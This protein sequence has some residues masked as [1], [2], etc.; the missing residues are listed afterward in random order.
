[1]TGDF[2]ALDRRD[3]VQGAALAMASLLYPTP[4]V[5][6][7]EAQAS[8]LGVTRLNTVQKILLNQ[9]LYKDVPAYL[10]F[11]EVADAVA[12]KVVQGE[13]AATRFDDAYQKFAQRAAE[14]RK[15]ALDRA[16]GRGV[17]LD[18][19]LIPSPAAPAISIA[20]VL[21]P[22][23]VPLGVA[24]SIARQIELTTGT[25]IPVATTV[26]DVLQGTPNVSLIP[27]L[28]GALT[29][30][31]LEQRLKLLAA[32][33]GV[34]GILAQASAFLAKGGQLTSEFENALAGVPKG[35]D[36]WTKGINGLAS[37]APQSSSD[38]AA[39]Q[40]AT[41]ALASAFEQLGTSIGMNP[42]TVSDVSK[43]VN[44]AGAALAGAMAGSVFGPVG[45]VVGGVV[46]L[47][48]GLLGSK[49][50][51][52]DQSALALVRIDTRITQ[53][54]QAMQVG[55]NAISAQMTAQLTSIAQSM[56]SGF[57]S[58][59]VQIRAFEIKTG[60]SLARIE[61]DLL[62]LAAT[63]LKNQVNNLD[64]VC[65]EHEIQYR[66]FVAGASSNR[67]HTEGE[68]RKAAWTLAQM[69]QTGGEGFSGPQFVGD[70]DFGSYL[71]N[72]SRS[73]ATQKINLHLSPFMTMSAFVAMVGPPEPPDSLVDEV[74]A[75]SEQLRDPGYRLG[76]EHLRDARY[77]VGK[78]HNAARVIRG[79][80]AECVARLA[81][82]ETAPEA[83]GLGARREVK[84]LMISDLASLPAATA[85]SDMWF[86]L[87]SAQ[88]STQQVSDV[89][90]LSGV[91]SD[92]SS[93]FKPHLSSHY[94][95]T[96]Q[97]SLPALLYVRR[98]ITSE[99]A[100]SCAVVF[101]NPYMAAIDVLRRVASI[102]MSQESGRNLPRASRIDIPNYATAEDMLRSYERSRM[103]LRAVSSV[104][105]GAKPDNLAQD[106]IFM[107]GP[108]PEGIQVVGDLLGQIFSRQVVDPGVAPRAPWS[109]YVQRA[110][111]YLHRTG[112]LTRPLVSSVRSLNKD[113]G[114]AE[115]ALA[116]HLQRIRSCC[117]I[118]GLIERRVAIRLDALKASA[119]GGPPPVFNSWFPGFKEY[120]IVA[121]YALGQ[122]EQNDYS[123]AKGVMQSIL[124]DP[125]FGSGN[126]SN[127]L[128]NNA[129]LADLPPAAKP[130][131]VHLGQFWG[132]GAEAC[133]PGTPT[134]PQL[135]AA[136]L[137]P[138]C[139]FAGENGAVLAAAEIYSQLKADQAL[140]EGS[141]DLVDVVQ[142]KFPNGIRQALRDELKAT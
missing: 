12:R 72:Y 46:G 109:E 5:G 130:Y 49:S 15:T 25:A 42:S 23:M 112:V 125:D 66:N 51:G 114:P 56:Q 103:P 119:S 22:L 71:A 131:P 122:T 47:V 99:L 59:S 19:V 77:P 86:L 16:I 45:T 110:I 3:F 48:S 135:L 21:S 62:S 61:A 29:G 38:A 28:P 20:S 100:D 85:P 74:K 83:K 32:E 97:N 44:V 78:Q 113:G 104:D 13:A 81:G 137:R 50:R 92:L 75:V 76:G 58:L 31:L 101:C 65:R 95:L 96:G 4:W 127:I 98:K 60:G 118:L 94:L 70:L 91:L 121:S 88:K 55:F 102:K 73:L 6:Q 67:V 11:D 39:V 134:S 93:S 2:S 142:K 82:F 14:D 123:F 36:A 40:A 24:G 116:R 124:G 68:V 132:W 133:R 52:P 84:E 141:A 129:I 17:A 37:G 63:S 126:V 54:G 27:V 35:I 33:S 115:G 79:I 107:S 136:L 111:G 140:Y 30:Y 1:M 43:G 9:L 69:I 53:L 8:Q 128:D 120:G 139:A 106:A 89:G 26:A 87:T 105:V 7:T 10:A 117:F 41:T 34:V 64:N 90:L 138:E 18:C 57:T 80:Q 108:L